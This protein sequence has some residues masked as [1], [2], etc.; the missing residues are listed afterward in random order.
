MSA[1]S[2]PAHDLSPDANT[3]RTRR[4]STMPSLSRPQRSPARSRHTASPP[5]T[6]GS[7]VAARYRRASI[8]TVGM[9]A[10]LLAR[11]SARTLHRIGQHQSVDAG[12]TM[13][14]PYRPCITPA[15]RRPS[16]ALERS[17]PPPT[18]ATSRHSCSS[19]SHARASSA[20]ANACPRATHDAS[21]TSS[22]NVTAA[23]AAIALNDAGAATKSGLSMACPSAAKTV[24]FSNARS[25]AVHARRLH[26]RR[27]DPAIPAR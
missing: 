4:A 18:K 27:P 24:R 26:V 3:Q 14:G 19:S 8:A 22:P 12:P 17:A 7:S 11:T 21:P 13:L 2:P 15:T 9:S 25:N 10:P 5:P 20:A 16:W 23:S 6:R 1:A